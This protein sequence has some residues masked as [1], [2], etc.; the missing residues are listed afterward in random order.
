MERGRQPLTG[1]GGRDMLQR[2]VP[3]YKNDIGVPNS[4][5][6]IYGLRQRV[7]RGLLNH[8]QKGDRARLTQWADDCLAP[9]FSATNFGFL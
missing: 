6:G 5:R 1:A 9:N 7:E 3:A 4:L 2:P 8:R